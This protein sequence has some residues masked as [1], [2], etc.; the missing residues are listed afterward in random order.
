MV[1]RPGTADDQAAIRSLLQDSRLPVDD[2]D[3]AAVGFTVATE[4]AALA[5]VVGLERFGSAGLLRSLAVRDGQRGRGVGGQLVDAVET[6]AIAPGLRHL[7]LLTTTAAQFFS[8]RGYVAIARDQA[9]AAVQRSAEFRSL[10]P[11]SATCMI[12]SLQSRHG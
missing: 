2:I 7:V 1:L 11:A 3:A 4:A 9:P 8:R 6:Q 10:C 12:K 5:G